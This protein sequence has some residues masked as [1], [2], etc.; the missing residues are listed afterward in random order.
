MK[1]LNRLFIAFIAT[2]FVASVL[3]VTGCSSSGV[4]NKSNG[5]KLVMDS[6]Y[7]QGKL[8][9][10]MSYF[11]R[12]NGEPKNRIQLRLVVK[13][14]FKSKCKLKKS[15]KELGATE[16]TFENGVKIITKKTNFQK[17]AITIYGGSK[18]GYYQLK[19]EEIP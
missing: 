7:K 9:N 10:G 15:I 12:E 18:G 16:Y 3:L 13:T 5:K 11:I 8:D 4:Q 2:A 14:G 17:N 1:K 6:A 19:E